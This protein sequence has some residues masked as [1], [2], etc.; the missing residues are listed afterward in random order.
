M[1]QALIRI[2]F[3]TGPQLTI[4]AQ[5]LPEESASTTILK[6]RGFQFVAE[7]DNFEDGKVWEWHLK[8]P[9]RN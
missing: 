3:D 9:R 1:A 7:L 2:A 4:A 8:N 5:T 6:K